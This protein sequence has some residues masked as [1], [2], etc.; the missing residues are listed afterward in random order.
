MNKIKHFPQ[1]FHQCKNSFVRFP[2]TLLLCFIATAL[3]VFLTNKAEQDLH[4]L[5]FF[6]SCSVMIPLSIALT[7]C[8]ECFQVKKGQIYT[9]AIIFCCLIFHYKFTVS[10]IS[11]SYSYKV[12]HLFIMF[13]LLVSFSPFLRKTNDKYF[14]QFNQTLLLKLVEAIFYSATSFIALSL[15]SS[16]ASYLFDLNL[17][18][19]FYLKI[20]IFCLFIVQTWIFLIGIPN[21]FN[22]GDVSYP[23]KLKLFLQFILI[24]LI[25]IYICILY[26]Y[27]GKVVIGWNIPK[28]LTS[29]FVS[30]LG[31]VGV[32]GY[33]ILNNKIAQIKVQWIL[34]FE[35]Y[36]F[37]LL[38]PLIG[39]LVVALNTRIQDYG[40]TINRYILFALALWLF[41]L[42]IFF[43]WKKNASLKIIP[44]SLCGLMFLAYSG[45]F[46]VYEF[47]FHSQKHIVQEFLKNKNYL[48]AKLE[49]QK[50]N[51]NLSLE[52][53]KK[54][55]ALFNYLTDHYGDFALQQILGAAFLSNTEESKNKKFYF[56][57][58]Y[59]YDT[60]NTTLEKLGIK[61]A[62]PWENQ[63]NEDNINLQFNYSNSIK[64]IS[65][66]EEFFEFDTFH[67]NENV[68]DKYKIKFAEKGYDLLFFNNNELLATI[69]TNQKIESLI[70]KIENKEIDWSLGTLLNSENESIVVENKIVRVKLL[71]SS[72]RYFKSKNK[73][74]GDTSYSVTGG[75]LIKYKK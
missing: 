47:S 8:L 42:S 66:Y 13:H 56:L 53:R 11:L 28:G 64:N 27:L 24:P 35:R 31:I 25:L 30:G 73:E 57:S 38:I 69:P 70:K 17:K 14:W 12:I 5:K 4:L 58:S 52:E 9:L 6:F 41:S 18:F 67:N 63:L 49:L 45:P 74:D 22:L 2:S 33:L 21:K 7:L 55:T 19:E 51:E 48:N 43:I 46:G 37:Y 16:L 50:S 29:W 68:V 62:Y 3:G 65:G 75:I 1:S 23:K 71:L 36:F 60:V 32:F 10:D 54:I 40:I 61:P 20:F 26:V 44:I 34:F 59:S 72:F 15:V 39:L